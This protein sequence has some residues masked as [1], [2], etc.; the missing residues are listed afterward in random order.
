MDENVKQNF[1]NLI[2]YQQKD[3]E[4]RKLNSVLERDSALVSM[5][6][7]KKAFN[8]AKQTIYDCEQNASGII[9]GYSELQ[10]YVDDNEAILAELERS[11]A[12]TEEELEARVKKLDSL[13][14]K[15]TSADRKAHDLDERSKKVCQARVDAIKSGNV[16]KQKFNEAK[17]KHGALVNSKSDELNKLKSEL[18]QMRSML[19]DN[20]YVEYQKLVDESKFPPVVQASGDEKKSLFNCGGCG[21]ALPQQGNALLKDKGWCRCDNCHRIIVRIK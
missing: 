6:V 3:I 14:S 11:E 16:A 4:L 8:D 17:E 19:D 10:K 13:K 7:H 5:N 20:L 9:D 12:A 1:I 15:F 21:L 18:E 2:K